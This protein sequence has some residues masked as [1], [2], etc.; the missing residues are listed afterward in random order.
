MPAA[1][2]LLSYVT[3]SKYFIVILRDIMIKGTPFSTFADQVLYLLIFAGIL[4]TVSTV[5][6]RRSSAI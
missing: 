5:R 2:Q 4:I 6:I 3:P 1:I